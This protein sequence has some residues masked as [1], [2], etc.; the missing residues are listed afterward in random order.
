M[1]RRS[2][3]G[4]LMGANQPILS[5]SCSAKVCSISLAGTAI[6]L[7]TSLGNRAC[8]PALGAD[9]QTSQ[10]SIFAVILPAMVARGPLCGI[11]SCPPCGKVD[12]MVALRYE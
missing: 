3:S 7:V 8:P 1:F 4:S 9:V 12:P 6:G 2:E 10:V 5:R 11:Y